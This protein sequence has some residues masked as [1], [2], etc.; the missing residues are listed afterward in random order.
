MCI[1]KQVEFERH[2]L[3]CLVKELQIQ[4]IIRQKKKLAIFNGQNLLVHNK[5][6]SLNETGIGK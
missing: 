2:G 3:S 6:L 4:W 5:Q 1:V